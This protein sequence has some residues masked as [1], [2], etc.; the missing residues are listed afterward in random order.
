MYDDFDF[1]RQ[2]G[3]TASK[4]TGPSTDHTTG[5]A[6]GH[7]I[8]IESSYPQ[9]AGDKAEIMTPVYRGSAPK[10]RMTFAYHMYGNTIGTLEVRV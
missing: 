7:Y 6:D 10:C 2:T 9:Q 1:T 4:G 3:Q 8:Y 5:S